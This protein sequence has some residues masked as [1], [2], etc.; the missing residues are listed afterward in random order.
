MDYR[1]PKCQKIVDAKSLEFGRNVSCLECKTTFV[2]DIEHLPKF[3]LPELIT[4]QLI[5]ANINKFVKINMNYG[6]P[7]PIQFSDKNGKVEITKGLII[8][9]QPED[10]WNRGDFTLKRYI[11]IEI[12]SKEGKVIEQFKIDLEKKEVKV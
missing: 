10:I 8:K 3:N 2:L 7:L 5:G 11:D 12:L 1:C 9:S 6:Y 4:I